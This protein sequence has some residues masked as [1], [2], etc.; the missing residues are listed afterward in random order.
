MSH[1][2]SGDGFGLDAREVE[3]RKQWLEL[4]EA[5]TRRIVEYEALTRDFV[6]DFVEQLYAHFFAFEEARSYF[7]DPAVL[8]HV[9]SRQRDYFL[10]LASGVYDDDYVASRVRVGSAHEAIGLGVKWWLGA[11]NFYMDRLGRRMFE[12]SGDDWQAALDAFFSLKKLLFFDIGIAV[13]TYIDRREHII[14]EQTAASEGARA[15]NQSKS[16]FL[17]RM[18]HEL[19]TPLNS[20]LGF[21][22][23]LQR[24]ELRADQRE[25][26]EHIMRAGRHLLELIN[27]VLDISRIEAGQLRLSVEPVA[28]DDVARDAVEL[29]RPEAAARRIEVVFE[30]SG[31]EHVRADQQ[32]LK[33]V[34]LNLLSNA[35]KFNH[36]GGHVVITCTCPT[37][38]RARVSV[39]DTG[40]GITAEHA[41]RLF[42]PFDRLGAEAL[43]IEG[44][45]LG[46]TLSKQ[47]VEAMGGILGFETAH[48]QGS[49]FWFEVERVRDTARGG[50]AAASPA[51]PADGAATTGVV[52]YIEDNVANQRLVERLLATRPGIRLL[53]AARGDVGIQL[54]AQHRP[55]LVL[56]DVHLGDMTGDDA[57]TRL[58]ADPATAGVPVVVVS[59]DATPAMIRRMKDRGAQAYLTKPLELTALLRVVDEA[60]GDA[61]AVG[62]GAQSD[63]D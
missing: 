8:D 31:G 37:D 39:R 22:Q 43:G 21:T 28:L 41:A 17:S 44:T 61:A 25:Y 33:Q 24:D 36:D 11:Y 57:I 53:T 6:D 63:S 49:T 20:I 1:A 59:A 9:K 62:L 15:A 23:L 2:M 51:A 19:R 32:R 55:D 48:G 10:R 42:T 58:K 3:R 29:I 40:L 13:E 5:D 14:R 7:A 38:E 54:A 47:L 56:L 35:V 60:L 50:P 30:A 52:L 12:Q 26:T 46:L 34:V 16:E 18:S 45:G 4:T 27:E